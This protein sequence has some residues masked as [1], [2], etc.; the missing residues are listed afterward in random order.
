[1]QKGP[2]NYKELDFPESSSAEDYDDELRN[3]NRG[4]MQKME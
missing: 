2:I 3:Y 1:M 4:Y